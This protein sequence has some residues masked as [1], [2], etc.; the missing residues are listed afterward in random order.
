MSDTVLVQHHKR[1]EMAQLSKLQIHQLTYDQAPKSPF[2]IIESVRLRSTSWS[3]TASS[4]GYF[5]VE[6]KD[7]RGQLQLIIKQDRSSI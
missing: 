3:C 4:Q 2:H 7:L 5:P 6:Q 1:P